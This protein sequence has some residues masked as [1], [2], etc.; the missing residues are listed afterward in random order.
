MGTN[1]LFLY[2][3]QGVTV[4]MQPAMFMWLTPWETTPSAEPDVWRGGWLTAA[5]VLAGVAGS[6]GSTD[7]NGTNA[8]A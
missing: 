4:W 2:E 5:V 7:A 1:G 3:P 6:F 8:L